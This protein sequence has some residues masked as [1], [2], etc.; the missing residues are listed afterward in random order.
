MGG[1]KNEA[2]LDTIHSKVI[3]DWAVG[4]VDRWEEQHPLPSR[5]SRSECF[6]AVADLHRL[7]KRDPAE[8]VEVVAWLFQS[9]KVPRF[10]RSPTKLRKLNRDG[11]EQTYA[12]YRRMMSVAGNGQP[13]P[14]TYV[15]DQAW[16]EQ[17]EAE[18]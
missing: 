18:P 11:D 13:Q 6:R 5:T 12:M 9:G 1:S 17:V 7:D 3:P 16:R 10:I 4:V 15:L 2:G 8:I 14:D